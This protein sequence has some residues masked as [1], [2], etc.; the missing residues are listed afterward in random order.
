MTFLSLNS[1][2]VGDA[3]A[4]ALTAALGR[5]ALPRLRKLRL[6]NVAIGDLGLVALTPALRRRP[7][8]EYLNLRNNPFGDE[9]IAALLAPLPPAGAL[10]PPT[11]VC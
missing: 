2:H 9:G 4:S 1:M 10:S 7:A 8:L 6:S 3:G 5:G 11:G